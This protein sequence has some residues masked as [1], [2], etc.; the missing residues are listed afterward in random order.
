[1]FKE[2]T[3]LKIY[4]KPSIIKNILEINKVFLNQKELSLLFDKN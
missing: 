3:K 4:D 2:N 1:M